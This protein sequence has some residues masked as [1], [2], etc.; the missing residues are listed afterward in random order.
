M[1]LTNLPSMGKKVVMK[2]RNMYVMGS[3][4]EHHEIPLSSL[5]LSTLSDMTYY[6]IYAALK[7]TGNSKKNTKSHH[8]V[9]DLQV[10]KTDL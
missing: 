9:N 6:C 4:P 7:T 5:Q 2:V 8:V 3:S 10:G 1:V